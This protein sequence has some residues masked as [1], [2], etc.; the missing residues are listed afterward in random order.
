MLCL[1]WAPDS[2]E[3]RL[4]KNVTDSNIPLKKDSYMK[5]RNEINNKWLPFIDYTGGDVNQF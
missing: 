3:R 1:W 2:G 5:S 4:F